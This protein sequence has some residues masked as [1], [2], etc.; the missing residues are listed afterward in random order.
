VGL[1]EG[2]PV[3]VHNL[4]ATP[5]NT[6]TSNGISFRADAITPAKPTTPP[7]SAS[8]VAAAASGE[9]AAGSGR[10]ARG[11]GGS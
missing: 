7:A 9:A 5:W 10:S 2:E 1:V 6:D 11:G 3:V 4:M 8:G